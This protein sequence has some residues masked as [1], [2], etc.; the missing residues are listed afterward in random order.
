MPPIRF[1]IRTTMVVIASLAVLMRLLP[2]SVFLGVIVSIAFV[3]VGFV[4]QVLIGA[5]TGLLA[6][7]LVQ[8][9]C[10]ESERSGEPEEA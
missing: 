8:A 10:P 7:S 1:R 6:N 2:L 9:R 4:V 3:L 5:V